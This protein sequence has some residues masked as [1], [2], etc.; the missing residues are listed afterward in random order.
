MR[1]TLVLLTSALMLALALVPAAANAATKTRSG[2]CDPIDPR[3]CLLPWPNDSFTV[4]DQRTDTERRVDLLG[5]DMPKTSKGK[6]ISA[7]AFNRADGFSP[8]TQILAHVPGLDLRKTGAATLTDLR[9]SLDR[10]QQIAVVNATTGQRHMIWAEIDV[11]NRGGDRLLVIHPASNLKYGQRYVVGLGRMIDSRGRRLKPSKAFRAMRD[12]LQTSDRRLER[13]RVGFER[14]FQTLAKAGLKRK[15][16]YLAW[17]FTVASVDNISERSVWIRDNAFAGLGDGNLVDRRIKGGAPRFALDAAQDFGPCGTDGCQDGENDLIVRTVTGTITVPCYLDKAGCPVGSRFRF[18]KFKK[19]A[20]FQADRFVD[21]PQRIKGNTMQVP[22]RCIVPRSALAGPSRLVQFMHSPYGTQD[23]LLRQP[24][25]AL[26]AEHNITICAARLAGNAAEDLQLTKDA[27][28][29]PDRFPAV[30]DRLQQGALNS[31]MLGRLMLHPKG[32]I[33]QPAFRTPSG[34]AAI[35][36]F[37]LYLHTIG[38]GPFAGMVTALSPDSVRSSLGTGGF[39]FSLMLPRSKSLAPLEQSLASAFPNRLD[40]TLV[41]AMLQGQWDRAESSGYAGSITQ[42]PLESTPMHTVYF[43]GA[44]GDHQVPTIATETH[45]RT[46]EAV[47]RE[48]LYDSG[49]SADKITGY[50]IVETASLELGSV[51]SMWDGGPVREGGL[52]GTGLAP[53]DATPPSAGVD[54]HELPSQTPQARQALSQFMRPDARF[55]DVCPPRRACRAA[56][57]A[58]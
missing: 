47:K 28:A 54:P 12:Q 26:A 8:A 3:A 21:L 43:Q 52:A 20:N 58:Y 13:R 42:D 23:E 4:A 1:R 36:T 15:D 51:L 31:L 40:R 5:G 48:P 6:R 38:S 16:L 56:G 55:V 27:L 14:M 44:V 32:L 34:G 41:R 18:Q 50:G 33:G 25:Q 22:F 11:A 19:T 7:A 45:A 24:L 53:L 35:D 30:A 9:R 39:R 37:E 49:R 46:V 2:D 57:W 10:T 17:D 29:D